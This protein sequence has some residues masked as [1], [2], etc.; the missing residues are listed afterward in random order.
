MLQAVY[1]IICQLGGWVDEL[2]S[3]LSDLPYSCQYDW[4]GY[5]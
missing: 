1:I 2:Y 3:D 4:Q 5:E